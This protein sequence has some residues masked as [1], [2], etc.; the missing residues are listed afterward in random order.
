MPTV[1]IEAAVTS[2]KAVDLSRISED[3]HQQSP[4]A[5]EI[6]APNWPAPRTDCKRRIRCLNIAGIEQF[7]EIQASLPRAWSLPELTVKI[8]PNLEPP[9]LQQAA[10]DE[11]VYEVDVMRNVATRRTIEQIYKDP[12]RPSLP[13]SFS[14]KFLQ[15]LFFYIFF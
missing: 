7:E 1:A 5:Q 11:L 4:Q 13:V 14:F 6:T 10:F 9:Y 15:T 12:K 3:S 2:I 8:R